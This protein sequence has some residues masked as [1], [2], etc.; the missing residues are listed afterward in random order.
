[1]VAEDTGG[2]A[3]V[4][5]NNL[6]AMYKEIVRDTSAYYLLGYTPAIEHRDGKFHDIRVRVKR[7]G[8]TVRARKGYLAPRRDAPAAV[9]RPLPEGV[10]AA[11][12]GALRMPVPVRGLAI[13]LFSAALKG[14]GRE[15]TVVIG[16]Q[17][18]GPLRLGDG[19]RMTVS[20]QVF[21][22]EGALRTGEYKVF[23]LNP[24]PQTRARFDSWIASNCRPG[25]TSCAWWL[26]SPTER[27]A[28]SSCPSRCRTST[29]TS[30]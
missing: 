20:Y 23:T 24:T 8:L 29:R 26:I 28:R 12:R 13:D 19:D 18:A 30:R 17:I 22:L 27:S 3:V 5:T 1:M 10:S 2:I 7:E 4:G 6:T 16:G 14:V 21:D 11:A 15:G 25:G 9:E